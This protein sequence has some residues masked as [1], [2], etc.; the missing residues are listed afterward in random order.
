MTY[1]QD[2]YA[3]AI[4]EEFNLKGPGIYE[5]RVEGVGTYVGKATKLSSRIRAYPNNVRKLVQS[6]PWHG[7]PLRNYRRIHEALREAHDKQLKVTVSVLENCSLDLLIDRE[8]F[9]LA[10]R[11]GEMNAVGLRLLNA[12]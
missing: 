7:N 3:R 5:W 11:R 4:G 12:T 6:L 1:R 2:Y 9:W 8:K 10:Q